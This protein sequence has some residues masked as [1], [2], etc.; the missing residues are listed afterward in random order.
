VLGESKGDYLQVIF[1]EVDTEIVVK[2]FQ[3][4][5]VRAVLE[6]SSVPKGLK[7]AVR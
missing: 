4:G 2:S 3:V 6:D 5:E 7:F 1:H